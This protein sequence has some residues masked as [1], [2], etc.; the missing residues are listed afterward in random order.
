MGAKTDRAKKALDA[1][2]PLGFSRKQAAPVLK[3]LLKIYNNNWELIE[4]ECYRAL[5]DAILDAQDDK[6]TPDTS[7]VMHSPFYA[8]VSYYLAYLINIFLLRFTDHLT[9]GTFLVFCIRECKQP[10]RTR[11]LMA[12]QGMIGTAMLLQAKMIMK[13]PWSRGPGWE[14]LTLDKNC[15]LD[16][17]DPLF[18]P[19]VLCLLH[20]KLA[21]GRLGL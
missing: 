18:P 14:W 1:M 6:Q 16:H 17:S 11:S 9:V 19:R 21:V 10:M 3:K 13:P 4:D 2:K 12:Q 20:H 15:N 5:A 7:Q 8:T